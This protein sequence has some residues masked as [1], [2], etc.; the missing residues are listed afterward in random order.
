MKK[1]TAR[2]HLN[3]T[4]IRSLNAHDLGRANGGESASCQTSNPLWGSCHSCVEAGCATSNCGGG[5]G[6][7]GS[8]T[9]LAACTVA[10]L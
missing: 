5:G 1:S 4:T 7:G 3:A 2:L 6:G 9:S 10:T 8:L